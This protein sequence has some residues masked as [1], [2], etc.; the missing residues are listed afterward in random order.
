MEPYTLEGYS[1]LDLG[2]D[3]ITAT[4]K[5]DDADFVSSTAGWWDI[6]HEEKNISGLV[7]DMGM[8]GYVGVTSGGVFIGFRN[9][10]CLLRIT[11]GS[12]KRHLVAYLLC[13]GRTTRLD[14]QVTLRCGEAW[15]RVLQSTKEGADVQNSVLSQARRRKVR[16]VTDNDQGHTVYIGSRTSTA[17]GR[18]YHKWA[19][20]PDRY[21]YGDVRYEVEL[22]KDHATDVVTQLE[23]TD[24][25]TGAWIAGFIKDWW[26]NRGTALP[27]ESTPHILSRWTDVLDETPLAQK[28]TWLYNQVGP[29]VKLLAEQ[30]H[31]AEVFR[32]LFGPQWLEYLL[33]RLTEEGTPSPDV[34]GDAPSGELDW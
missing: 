26:A 18:A 30:G 4:L 20:D 17:F 22:H 12:A 27:L 23:T 13:P 28:L 7:E 21:E 11:G 1:V 31:T 6:L 14:L 19:K 32:V 3:Y 33:G 9:D 8:L 29:T 5:R 24:W 34:Y 16:V 10:G 2:C 25:S 15:H